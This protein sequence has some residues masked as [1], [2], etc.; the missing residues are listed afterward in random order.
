MCLRSCMRKM[1]KLITKNFT[2][3]MSSV[4]IIK[5]QKKH[6]KFAKKLVLKQIKKYYKKNNIP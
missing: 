5:K 3:A 4:A 1:K 2:Q 6:I